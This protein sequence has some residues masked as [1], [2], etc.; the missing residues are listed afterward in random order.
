MTGQDIIA[1]EGLTKVYGDTKVVND[2]TFALA[3]G[4][5]VALLGHNGAGKTTLMKLMLGLI[6]PNGG[7]VRV[8]GAVPGGHAGREARKAIGFLPESVVFQNSM[9][10]RELLRHYARL[11]RAPLTQCDA[12]LAQVGLTQAAKK[13]IKT[14]SK[15]MRQRLGLAQALLG[16]PRLLLLDEPTTGLDPASRASFYE[17][18]HDLTREGVAVMLSSHALTEVE[19]QT[20][21][22]AIMKNGVLVA[23]GSLDELRRAASLPV[24][25]EV[26]VGSGED[27]EKVARLDSSARRINN[28]AVNFDCRPDSKMALVRRI[29]EMGVTVHDLDIHPPTL[30]ALYAHFRDREAQPK[31][32]SLKETRP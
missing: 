7:A 2:V 25:I 1:L 5:S 21:R 3:P 20:D 28:H 10:G 15:G 16:S 17:T 11:K 9:T 24:R 23:A 4:E 29:A 26:K 8:L 13:R 6:R 12:L 32:T 30:E 14:Y 19:A 18:L 27:A 22:V 31:E